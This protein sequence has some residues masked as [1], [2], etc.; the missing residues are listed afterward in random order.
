MRRSSIVTERRKDTHMAGLRIRGLVGSMI[1]VVGLA[2]LLARADDPPTADA[3]FDGLLARAK[4]DPS[5]TNW[6]ALRHAYA[7][8]PRYHPYDVGW[9]DEL[10]KIRETAQKGDL[11]A[12]EA[13]VTKLRDRDGWSRIDVLIQAE[14][15]F[16]KLGQ[17][18][19]ARLHHQFV[20]GYLMTIIAPGRGKSIDKAFEVL[21]VDEEYLTL[22]LIGK[23]RDEQALVEEKGHFFDVL[24]VKPTP[25]EP[26]EK[27]YF[28]VDLPRRW[29]KGMLDTSKQKAVDAP[30]K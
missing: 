17:K 19:K 26:A 30:K 29:L 1:G 4:A 11:K 20:E 14:Q 22:H 15:I 24:T 9:R 7:A 10:V 18:E 5:R 13:E 28:N 25:D 21:Y 3:I 23:Q 12:A 6:K 16:D 2:T 8:T 27:F